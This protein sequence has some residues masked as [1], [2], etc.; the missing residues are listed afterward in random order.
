MRWTTTGNF[1]FTGEEKYQRLQYD[2]LLRYNLFCACLVLHLLKICWQSLSQ[3]VGNHHQQ[4]CSATA[5]PTWV[6]AGTWQSL[7]VE[8]AACDC[9]DGSPEM[10]HS[11]FYLNQNLIQSRASAALFLLS[12][13]LPSAIAWISL[14]VR[15]WRND[16][17]CLHSFE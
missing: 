10:A 17:H 12:S 9:A 2:H 1:N 7:V 4:A 13:P 14:A 11:F 5:T 3:W 15:Q 16:S 6:A 8:V